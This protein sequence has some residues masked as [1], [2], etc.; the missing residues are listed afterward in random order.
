MTTEPT[1]PVPE[2]PKPVTYVYEVRSDVPLSAIVGPW[3]TVMVSP[4]GLWDGLTV[5]DK[6]QSASAYTPSHGRQATITLEL[7]ERL[8]QHG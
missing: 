5:R 2:L 1:Q 6:V 8:T 4:G 7:K 3:Q